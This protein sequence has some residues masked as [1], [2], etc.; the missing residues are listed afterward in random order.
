M[1]NKPVSSLQEGG[2]MLKESPTGL[3]EMVCQRGTEQA[4]ESHGL[5]LRGDETMNRNRVLAMA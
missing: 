5:A 4:K 3:L 2:K 1:E